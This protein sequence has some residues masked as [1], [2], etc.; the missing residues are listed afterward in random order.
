MAYD[1]T[2]LAPGELAAFLNQHPSW[3]VEGGELTK[4]FEFE[5]FLQAIAFVDKVAAA[6]ERADHHPDIDIRYRKVTLRLITHAAGGLTYR[7]AQLAEECEL[8]A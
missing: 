3:K 1:K 8:L 7:D 6:A 5:R 4:T 2:L